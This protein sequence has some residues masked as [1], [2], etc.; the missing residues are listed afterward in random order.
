M[1][2]ILTTLALVQKL[3]VLFTNKPKLYWAN[4]N[5]NKNDN[6]ISG[7]CL[8]RKKDILKGK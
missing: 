4:S 3:P 6:T 1:S 8:K 7:V 5:Q 2:S